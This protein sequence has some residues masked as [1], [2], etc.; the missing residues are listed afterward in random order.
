MRTA[1]LALTVIALK[2]AGSVTG[3]EVDFFSS[4]GLFVLLF[5]GFFM[6]IVVDASDAQRAAKDF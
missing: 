6:A 4:V 1:L 3:T 2:W 5:W